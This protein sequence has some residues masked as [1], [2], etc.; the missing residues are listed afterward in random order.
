MK[1]IYGKLISAAI[2]STLAASWYFELH[3]LQSFVAVI[4]WMLITL[5]VLAGIA[6]AYYITEFDEGETKNK[7]AIKRF[8]PFGTKTL[9]DFA[10]SGFLSSVNVGLLILIDSPVV[11][12]LYLISSLCSFKMSSSCASRYE[13]ALDADK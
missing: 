12:A 13:K 5:V 7:D 11:A 1:K 4:Y 2:T 3:S 9:F 10:F 8:K 6:V